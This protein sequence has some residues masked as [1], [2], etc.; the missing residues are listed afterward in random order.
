MHNLVFIVLTKFA[1]DGSIVSNLIKRRHFWKM[2][3]KSAEGVTL[4]GVP[5][6]MRTE[7][8]GSSGEARILRVPKVQGETRISQVK[9]QCN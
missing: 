7:M 5:I 2:I 9:G 6:G 8:F 1:K 4:S 3:L